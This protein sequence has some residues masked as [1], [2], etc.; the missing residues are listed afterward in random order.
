MC[1]WLSLALC[2]WLVRGGLQ[3][4][5]DFSGGVPQQCGLHPLH[6]PGS[7]L[8]CLTC[9]AAMQLESSRFLGLSLAE[10]HCRS[11]PSTDTAKLPSLKCIP[12][13]CCL[14]K[15]CGKW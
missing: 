5:S 13:R 8:P 3:T 7:C 11:P 6:P 1:A 10:T 9:R 4:G 12:F 14:M 2:S 15:P